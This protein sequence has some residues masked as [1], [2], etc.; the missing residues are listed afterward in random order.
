MHRGLQSDPKRPNKEGDSALEL[1][2]L[3]QLCVNNEAET[4]YDVSSITVYVIVTNVH[5]RRSL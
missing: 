5:R 1:G 4:S 3:E 2:E